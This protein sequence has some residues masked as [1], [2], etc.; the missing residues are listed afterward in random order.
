MPVFYRPPMSADTSSDS[1]SSSSS[2]STSDSADL[3][4]LK[5]GATCLKDIPKCRLQDI[6][7]EIDDCFD[8]LLTAEASMWTLLQAIFILTRSRPST[9]TTEFRCTRQGTGD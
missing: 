8:P 3:K 1:S 6:L 4:P 9:K 7:S 2:D 5:R